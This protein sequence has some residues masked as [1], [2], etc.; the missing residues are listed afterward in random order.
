MAGRWN[1]FSE[2][3][4]KKVKEGTNLTE[5]AYVAKKQSSK[6][7]KS[8]KKNVVRERMLQSPSQTSNSPNTRVPD[9]PENARLSKT[10]KVNEDRQAVENQPLMSE[11]SLDSGCGHSNGSASPGKTSDITTPDTSPAHTVCLRIKEDKSYEVLSPESGK[12]SFTLYDFQIRQKMMEEQNRQRKDALAKALADRKKQTHEEA[13]RLQHIQ[14]ELHKLD[15][16]LSND[17]SILRNQ[18]EEASIEFTEAQKRYDRA[19]KEFLEAKLLLFG[20]LERKEMLTEHLCRIIEQNEARKARKLSLLMDQLELGTIV[21]IP[22]GQRSPPGS[23]TSPLYGLDQVSYT[24]CNT[25]KSHQIQPSTVYD[26]PPQE[27]PVAREDTRIQDGA[28]T[29]AI[30]ESNL[31]KQEESGIASDVPS[32]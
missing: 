7:Q 5:D 21:D 26:S 22:L 12:S 11:G 19:E 15:A 3:D 14:D 10:L 18:I 25:L 1:G 32:E 6:L 8:V 30:L 2:A 20:K 17:V 31:E 4:I 27:E 28:D 9:I 23:V 16:L 24:A 29:Q 13:R